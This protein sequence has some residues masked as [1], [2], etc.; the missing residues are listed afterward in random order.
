MVLDG[1]FVLYEV[2]VCV[3]VYGVMFWV[4]IDYDEVGGQVVVCEV[5]V[6]LGMDYLLG[7]EIFVIWV[8]CML[9]IV[10][11]GID[12]DNVDLVQGLE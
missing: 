11:L 1:M 7:V 10:G 8:G 6:V 5:V 9:Y 3:V 4:L 2:V 12:L